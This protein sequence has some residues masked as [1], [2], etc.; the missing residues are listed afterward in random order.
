MISFNEIV[1]RLSA[2][3]FDTATAAKAGLNGAQDLY[4]FQ[5][6]IREHGEIKVV[7]ETALV[8][9][10]RYRCSYTEAVSM[11]SH[12]VQAMLELSEGQD[13]FQTVRSRLSK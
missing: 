12:R 2:D 8:L 6:S 13:T 5:M 1:S 11:A 4:H 3:I 7:N 10:E 9:Q